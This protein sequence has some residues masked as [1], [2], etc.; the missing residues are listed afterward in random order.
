MNYN[1]DLNITNQTT[2]N[3]YF[4]NTP[5]I[6]DLEIINLFINSG[7]NF[8]DDSDNMISWFNSDFAAVYQLKLEII[9]KERD[10]TL[11]EPI[12]FEKKI[13]IL[14]GG[15]VQS[16]KGS[17]VITIDFKDEE[18][19]SWLNQSIEINPLCGTLF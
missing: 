3:S 2:G 16:V 9:Y 14:V 12:T 13:E 15:E 7:F 1:Y 11:L 19:F 8:A 6:Q 17:S 5:I 10:T 4:S 18:F